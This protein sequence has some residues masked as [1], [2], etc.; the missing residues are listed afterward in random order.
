[1]L[2]RNN[3]LILLSLV[4][5]FFG[6]VCQIYI[7]N[8]Y[9][10]D[11]LGICVLIRVLNSDSFLSMFDFGISEE[12]LFE[13]KINFNGFVL[14]FLIGITVLFIF[15]INIDYVYA[16]FRPFRYYLFTM[17][18]ASFLLSMNKLY[19]KK[20]NDILKIRCLDV[21]YSILYFCIFLFTIDWRLI[22]ICLTVLNLILFI[23]TFRFDCFV[24]FNLGTY[25]FNL[26]STV[27]YYF[28]SLS[29]KLEGIIITLI[30]PS[31]IS[32]E[33]LGL[34]DLITKIPKAF[35]SQLGEFNSAKKFEYLSVLFGKNENY[36]SANRNAVVVILSLIVF[37][38][39]L[40]YL[41]YFKVDISIFVISIIIS[42]L[43]IGIFYNYFNISLVKMMFYKDTRVMSVT[44]SL[45]RSVIFVIFLYS[46]NY[47]RDLQRLMFVWYFLYFLYF[48]FIYR[49]CKI[50][51]L[52]L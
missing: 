3:I 9:G 25:S 52:L 39:N 2:S 15:S 28:S 48:Y 31:Y 36:K 13:N 18:G 34:F 22:F 38:L 45:V 44:A 8:T 17:V 37:L 10:L 26:Y 23:I 11:I 1:V 33:S 16:G 19:Y 32:V 20:V 27:V 43:F 12:V 21:I 29:S 49:I 42:E 30:I 47:F 4:V 6:F 5:L 14:R 24:I 50:K 41:F 35:K 46:F 51:G 7:S 40:I